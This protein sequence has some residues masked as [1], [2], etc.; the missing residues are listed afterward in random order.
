[1]NSLKLA[2]PVKVASRTEAMT[3]GFDVKLA[4]SDAFIVE[5]RVL[6][7]DHLALTPLTLVPGPAVRGVNQ[8]AGI[9]TAG[10][11]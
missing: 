1:M 3:R 2:T 7:K 9:W 11:V 5:V 8:H 10:Q 4:A 6:D